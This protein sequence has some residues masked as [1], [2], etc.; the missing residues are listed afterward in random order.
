MADQTTPSGDG[1]PTAPL[2]A[3]RGGRNLPV[4]IAS[5]VAMAG[6]F[7][8]TLAAGPYAF[9]TFVFV[10]AA[11]ALLELDAAFRGTRGLRPATPVAIAGGAVTVFGAYAD[12][13][14]AQSLGLVLTL[15]G[16]LAWVLLDRGRTRVPEGS[17][18]VA[19]SMAATVLM[20]LWVPF[21]ASFAGLLLARDDGVD[22]VLAAVALCVTADI[23]AYGWGRAF[24]RHKLA[25]TV[26]PAKTWEGLV[27]ALVTVLA[28][29]A[30]VTAQVVPGMS[31]V[32]ALAFG[33]AIVVAATLGDLSESLVKRDLG[34]KDL[35]RIV[36][37]HGGIMDRVDAIILALPAA[38]LALLALGL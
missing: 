3:P 9:L 21:A 20:V 13:P 17:K 30:L 25:P 12:G 14:A 32:Q 22:Y 26:S 33:A 24:G 5:G 29:S 10:I 19:A 18:T 23:G 16:T 37:G 31:V 11:I 1:L 15:L 36:P 2:P 38:H 35:G 4:A 8:L 6:L 34:V 7:T 28:L 27:G